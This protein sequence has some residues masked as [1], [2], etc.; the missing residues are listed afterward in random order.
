MPCIDR[1]GE[2]NGNYASPF[3]D[4][5][6]PTALYPSSVTRGYFIYRLLKPLPATVMESEVRPWFE[7]PGGGVQQL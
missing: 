4:R 3:A 6:I 7:M 5:Y 2:P 1:F